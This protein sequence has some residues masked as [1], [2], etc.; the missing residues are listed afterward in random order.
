MSDPA[1]ALQVALV[2]ALKG[3]TDAGDAVY[4]EVPSEA[5]QIEIAGHLYP[6]I[7]FGPGQ[8][9]PSPADC[10]DGSESFIQIDVWSR[11]SGYPEVKR[12]AS[13]VRSLLM[14]D[15]LSLPL[16]GHRLELME[17]Q[18][19]AY[20]RDPDGKTS[21]ARITLRALTQAV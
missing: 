5:R 11:R 18:D 17:V 10:Y 3:A 6:Q 9:I 15:D 19:T 14:D 20:S 4:D 7:T 13:D 16:D 21:R 12:I 2:A 8:T 1:Y